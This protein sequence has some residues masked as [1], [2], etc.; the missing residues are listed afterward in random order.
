MAKRQ[1]TDNSMSKMSKALRNQLE[2]THLG[3]VAGPDPDPELDSDNESEIETETEAE[4]ESHLPL[5]QVQLL[6]HLNADKVIVQRAL[7]KM[8]FINYAACLAARL[9]SPRMESRRRRR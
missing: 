5:G 2:L 8:D 4:T 1:R 3:H 6:G 9:K 7:I